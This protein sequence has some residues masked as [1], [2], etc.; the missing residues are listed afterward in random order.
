MAGKVEVILTTDSHTHEG[1]PCKKDEVISLWPDQAERL[2]KAGRAEYRT[3]KKLKVE[4]SKSK[5]NKKAEGG[6]KKS[7]I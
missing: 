2:V 7:T 5:V 6:S 4:S 1:K 3:E